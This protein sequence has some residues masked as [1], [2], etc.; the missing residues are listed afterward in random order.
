MGNRHRIGRRRVL[1]GHRLLRCVQIGSGLRGVH[2]VSGTKR[3]RPRA[4]LQHNAV[5]VFE[6]QRACKDVARVL[7]RVSIPFVSLHQGGGVIGT[8]GDHD[9][10]RAQLDQ[11]TIDVLRRHEGAMMHGALGITAFPVRR[12]AS[13]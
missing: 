3:G 9:P 10:L 13:S 6:V 4:A 12:M 2:H 5:R 8:L 11:V 1:D 7:L